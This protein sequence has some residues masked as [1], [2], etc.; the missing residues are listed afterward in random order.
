MWGRLAVLWAATAALIAAFFI[1]VKTHAV[2]L[3]MPVNG[4][5]SPQQVEIAAQWFGIA[6]VAVILLAILALFVWLNLRII[7]RY[8]KSG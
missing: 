1:P 7:R 2:K 6:V 3:D 8:R 5:V 4:S